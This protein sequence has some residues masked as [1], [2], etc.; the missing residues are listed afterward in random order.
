MRL[1]ASI[2]IIFCFVNSLS[3]QRVTGKV[4]DKDTQEPLVGAAVKILNSS[5]I[6]GAVTDENGT[7]TIENVPTGRQAIECAYIGYTSFQS[8]QFILTSVKDYNIEVEM[9]PSVG[10]LKEVTITASQNTNVPMNAAILLGGRSFSVEETERI[11]ASINDPARMALS[12][13]SVASNS[14]DVYNEIIIRGNSPDGVLWRLEGLDVL[15]PNHFGKIGTSGGAVS[16]FSAQLLS[17]SDF[18]TGAMPA[19]Y[20]NASSGAFD[21]HLRKGNMQKYEKR[22]RFS[23][24]GTDLSVEGPIK[25]GRSS[26]LVNYRYSTLALLNKIG[27]YLAGPRV[28]TGFQDL[29]FNVANVSKDNKTTWTT[30]GIVGLSESNYYPEDTAKRII[31]KADNWE[32]R[33]YY[34]KMA[35]IGTSLTHTLSQKATLKA[36][37]AFGGAYDGHVQDTLNIKDQHSDG[38]NRRGESAMIRPICC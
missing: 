17:R 7:F 31:G 20:S 37:I 34:Y 36:A 28:L 33:H 29:C 30:F 6:I 38:R 8:E 18:I 11:A 19:E 26:F 22:V 21:V 35:T 4:T 5:P 3:A 24:I 10:D 23:F 25:K 15:N 2:L 27:F 12:Y 13:P 16:M 9:R 14:D 32:D 1:I